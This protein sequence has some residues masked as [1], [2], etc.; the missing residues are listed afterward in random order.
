MRS[1]RY[2][3]VR[4]DKSLNTL[5]PALLASGHSLV[6][7]PVYFTAPRAS[8]GLDISELSRLFAGPDPDIGT[9]TPTELDAAKDPEVRT[10]KRGTI[11][12]LAFFS[13]SSAGYVLPLLQ[14]SVREAMTIQPV[15]GM[16][17]EV[18]GEEEG[19]G[20]V[21]VKVFAIGETTRKWLESQGVRVDRVAE[22]PDAGGLLNAING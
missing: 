14:P 3:F 2:L 22:A 17:V 18:D 6:E 4:G 8:L 21:I 10:N 13:P 19:G 20:K 11:A 12:W 1:K 15:S 5:Q 7:I 16:Q 9:N